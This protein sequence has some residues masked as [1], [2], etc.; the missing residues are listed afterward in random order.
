[1]DVLCGVVGEVPGVRLD[2]LVGQLNADPEAAQRALDGLL[3]QARALAEG[4]AD[5]SGYLASWDPVIAGIVAAASG[6]HQAA[7]AVEQHL[8]ASQDSADWGKLAAALRAVVHGER[9]DSLLAGLDR[10]DT[11]ITRRALDA[12]SGEVELPVALWQAIP[13]TGLIGDMMRAAGGDQ[14]AA[15]QV[16]DTLTSWDSNS[17]LSPLAGTLRRILDGDR[18]PALATILSHLPPAQTATAPETP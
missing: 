10:I 11:A 6:D 3:A 13:V 15:S 5:I 4:D 18:A 14:D 2:R 9:G 8:T 17:G 16:T 1:V 12:L 7:A